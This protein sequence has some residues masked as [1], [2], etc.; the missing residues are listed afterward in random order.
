[1]NDAASCSAASFACQVASRR[2]RGFSDIC[3]ST[4][5][6]FRHGPLFPLQPGTPRQFG[7]FPGSNHLNFETRY[8]STLQGTIVSIFCSQLYRNVLTFP[9]RH[10]GE[11]AG[12]VDCARKTRAMQTNKPLLYATWGNAPDTAF[13]LSVIFELRPMSVYFVGIVYM[14]P[15]ANERQNCNSSKCHCGGTKRRRAPIPIPPSKMGEKI[16]IALDEPA[17]PTPPA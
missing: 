6:S 16:Q 2:A 4:T 10:G 7:V 1:M 12:T 13:Q 3:Q 8:L 11:H 15:S 5:A 17:I 14:Q 9:R